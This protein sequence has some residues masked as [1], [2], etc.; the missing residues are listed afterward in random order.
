[1][2]G[3]QRIL[4]VD[5]DPTWREI[6]SDSLRERGTEVEVCESVEEAREAIQSGRF[7]EII[8]DGL[9]GRWTDVVECAGDSLVT[10]LSMNH[11]YE[12]EAGRRGVRFKDKMNVEI[13]KLFG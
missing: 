11:S 4:V 7:A 2:E 12:E 5:D 13:D 9:D 6:L 3:I 8:T 10:L 1:M